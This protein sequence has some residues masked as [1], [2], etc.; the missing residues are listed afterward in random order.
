MAIFR[1]RV[2][3][4]PMI[5]T[6]ASSTFAQQVPAGGEFRVNT[7]TVGQQSNSTVAMAPSGEFVVVWESR[8]DPSTS[9]VYGQR[10]D[11]RGLPRGAEF[12]LCA[13]LGIHQ[14]P[15]MDM[16][17]KGN[18]VV[19]WGGTYPAP[20]G[21]FGRRFD[22]SGVQL[23]A[24]FRV[25]S[26]SANPS[27]VAVHPD[28]RFVV[29]GIAYQFPGDDGI[30]AWARRFTADGSPLGAEFLVNT[31]TTSAQQQPKVAFDGAG[32]FVVAWYSN[33]QD[34]STYGV[35]A[36]RFEADGKR[37]GAE[38]QVNTY[39]T[40]NQMFVAADAAPNGDFIISWS[41]F[42]Q[43]GSDNGVFA[44]RYFASGSPRGGEFQVSTSTWFS[45]ASPRVAAAEGGRFV[46]AWTSWG[47]DGSGYGA[48]AQRFDADG[49]RMGAEF[50]VN[51][52][53]T[54]LQATSDV[55]VDPVGNL[56]SVVVSNLQDG[57][58]YGVFGRRYGGLLPAAL[59]VDAGGNGVLEP[60][61]TADVRPSWRNVNGVSQTFAGTLLDTAGIPST[62]IDASGSYGTVAD[63]AVG[64]CVDC[65]TV[66][67]SNPVPRPAAHLDI[68]ALESISPEEHGQQKW[69]R[70]HL[71]R[72][73]TDVP[74]ASPFYRFIET[75][76]HHG[77]TGGCTATT[78]CPTAS[79][80][81]EQMAVFVL[82]G[83]EGAGYA[84]P[85]CGAT[86]VFADVPPSSP[87][88]RWIEEL[89]RRG[90]VS[91]CGGGNYCPASDVTREQM[92]VF[93][94]RTLDPALIPPACGTPMFNDVPAS[95]PF[96]PWIEE[97]ARRGVVTGCG[98]GNYCP[99]SSVTRE[100]V[101]VFIGA[102]FGLMLY[103]L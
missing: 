35:V 102:A 83:K 41:S 80:T 11:A 4:L 31:Y 82:V 69:W 91:G 98:G 73:F 53:S 8:P 86:P 76:L 32:G 34:G 3:A 103:G 66:A 9:H 19:V 46:V 67:V 37:L 7:Q 84:P 94:L 48:F 85:P 62:V 39:T 2:L 87:F 97:L 68:Q 38:L 42:T 70:V 100:Q 17:A 43:D 58:G 72:T 49:S 22:S 14:F 61:E 71:G 40:N 77:V 18:F 81:R 29:A 88:C 1:R 64:A 16:D 92:S 12:R 30:G 63:G 59:A 78:Y 74:I 55:A 50:Q 60:G 5:A 36:Q 47:Q 44:Q 57:S 96:C 27:D 51:A 15:Q 95:S 89:A 13:A 26:V 25:T 6:A 20:N 23:G 45:Q 33:G 79:T 93:V 75:L 24:E 54:G 52:F 10:Y 90:V 28:G 56:T 21:V 65:Y 99:T 101:G